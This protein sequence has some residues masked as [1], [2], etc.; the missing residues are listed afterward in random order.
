MAMSALLGLDAMENSVAQ[1]DQTGCDNRVACTTQQAF[2]N[3][4]RKLPSRITLMLK[5][6][7]VAST[8]MATAWRRTMQK[9]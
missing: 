7:W 9:Q 8:P 4:N 5:S 2:M 6:I 3:L 1:F